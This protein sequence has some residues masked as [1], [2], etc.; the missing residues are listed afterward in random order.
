MYRNPEPIETEELCAYGCNQQAKYRTPTN[1][2]ICESSH[3]KCPVNKNK[4]SLAC[5]KSYETGKRKPFLLG[6]TLYDTLTQEQKD[7]MAWNRGKINADFSYNG[8]GSHK[9]V[10]IEERGHKCQS[11]N[12]E[13]WLDEPIPLE[14]EHTDGDNK[15]NVKENLLLLCPNC[16][17]KTTYYRG[18]NINTGKI[19][20]T[21]EKLLTLIRN[22]TNIRQALIEAGLTP[23]GANYA[24][25]KK[26]ALLDQ[27]AESSD[28]KS[29]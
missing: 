18:R 19:K 27:Q 4:N 25:A 6:K 28:L 26:L 5:K 15:N 13:T 9:K 22:T 2:L 12:L 29:L 10:L 24:R 16:H 23:K 14:L 21:D 20:V 3:S 17:A 1:K 11:C 8:K 7:K